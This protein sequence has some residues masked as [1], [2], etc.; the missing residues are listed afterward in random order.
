MP[1]SAAISALESARA[2]RAPPAGIDEP[3]Q[4]PEELR[5][6]LDL[7]EDDELVLV[8]RQV[9]RGLGQL[10]P[11]GFGLEIEIDRRPRLGHF[12]RQR[13]LAY[14]TRPQERHRRGFSQARGERRQQAAGKHPC[15]CGV[16]L[17]K[18]K[19]G[20][21]TLVLPIE[22]TLVEVAAITANGVNLY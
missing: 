15:N 16:A 13:G 18:C 19:D 6:A 14:L 10:G 2:S 12:E 17:R 22:A 1:R 8:L 4:M 11:V 3:A 21:F 7:V 9:E 20:R 5:R